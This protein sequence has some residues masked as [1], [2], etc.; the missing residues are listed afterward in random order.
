[1]SSVILDTPTKGLDRLARVYYDAIWAPVAYRAT[2]SVSSTGSLTIKA[3]DGP[4]MATG[5]TA[6]IRDPPS[7]EAKKRAIALRRRMLSPEDTAALESPAGLAIPS[8]LW[9]GREYRVYAHHQTV[10][11]FDHGRFNG[12]LELSGLSRVPLGDEH[13]AE[14]LLLRL[15]EREALRVGWYQPPWWR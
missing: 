14:I 8:K 12:R 10:Q 6:F 7:E 15:R 9:P 4:K 1:M 13:L 5:D 11:V 3:K 2:I